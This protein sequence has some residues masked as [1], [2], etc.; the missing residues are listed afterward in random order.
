MSTFTREVKLADI[1]YHGVKERKSFVGW[2]DAALITGEGLWSAFCH[3]V[4]LMMKPL[5]SWQLQ[6]Q[7]TLAMIQFTFLLTK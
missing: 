6:A 2:V 7:G 4:R 3:D 1:S 5:R